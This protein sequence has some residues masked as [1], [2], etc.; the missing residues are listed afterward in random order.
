M[1][2]ATFEQIA[3]HLSKSITFIVVAE[4]GAG[5]YA[6]CYVVARCAVA[7][8]ALQ[9]EIGGAADA[10]RAQIKVAVQGWYDQAGKHVEG[11]QS[12][13][14][15]HQRQVNEI[16]DRASSEPGPEALVLTAR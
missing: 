16:I 9:V 1:Q 5:D 11:C 12:L 3:T 6:Q 10:K 15:L 7:V 14:I 4:A 2:S 8:A 13:R